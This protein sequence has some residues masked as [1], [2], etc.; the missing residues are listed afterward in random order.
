MTTL[1]QVMPRG[2]IIASSAMEASTQMERALFT[3]VSSSVA[4]RASERHPP[5][6]QSLL[7]EGVTLMQF[8]VIR[9]SPSIILF[10]EDLGYPFACAPRQQGSM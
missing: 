7:K 2:A 8:D 5:I 4:E 10:N 1:F 3:H 6:I 9:V